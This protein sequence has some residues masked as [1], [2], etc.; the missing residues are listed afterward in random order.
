M[1]H[2]LHMSSYGCPTYCGPLSLTISSGG[3]NMLN[4]CADLLAI[5]L[6]VVECSFSTK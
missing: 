3:S 5:E 4:H 1:F 2:L 6:L